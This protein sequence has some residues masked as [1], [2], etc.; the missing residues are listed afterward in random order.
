MVVQRRR[1]IH[2]RI[3]SQ[4]LEPKMKHFPR[5]YGSAPAVQW[6]K[7]QFIYLETATIS[8]VVSKSTMA[9]RECRE[10]VRITPL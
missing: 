7:Q 8:I 5:S 10:S 4:N 2:R 1:V 9:A 3:E 6:G